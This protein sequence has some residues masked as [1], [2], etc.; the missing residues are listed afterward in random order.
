MST[1]VK[2]SD[3]LRSLADNLRGEVVKRAADRRA[4]A[5]HMVTAAAG[6]GILRSKLEAVRG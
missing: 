2:T 5:A 3:M 4:K 6:L 1:P